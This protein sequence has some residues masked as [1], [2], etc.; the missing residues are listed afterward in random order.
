[1]G[2]LTARFG[3]KVAMP[4]WALVCRVWT[5]RRIVLHY[6]VTCCT[7]NSIFIRP[8]VH[9]RRVTAKVI[10]RWRSGCG[11]FQSGRLPPIAASLGPAEDAPEQVEDENDLCSDRD[12][13]RDR[14]E[15]LERQKVGKVAEF[16]GLRVAPRA[17]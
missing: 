11:P 14:Y 16:R 4:D 1:R 7:R 13:G 5:D 2:G 9:D 17:S 10:V 8:V 15:A 6:K 12:E 3:L